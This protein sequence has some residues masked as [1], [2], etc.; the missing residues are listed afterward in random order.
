MHIFDASY[1]S[2]PNASLRPSDA[3]L[4]D[5]ALIQRQL[6]STRF[7]A[8]QPSIYGLDNSLLLAT[9]RHSGLERARG[10]AVVDETVTD[11][12]LTELRANGVRGVRFN[13]VQNG[14]TT[15]EMLESLDP[16]LNERNLHVQVHARPDQL[17]DALPLL[18][19]LRSELV[20]DHI[21][22]LA[23]MTDLQSKVEDALY[24][25][26]DTGRA[27]L[28]LS[29]PYLASGADDPYDDI[30]EC[31]GTI[32]RR[33]P[34]RIVWGTDWPHATERGPQNEQRMLA[35][36]RSLMPSA[37]VDRAVFVD[38]PAALYGFRTPTSAGSSS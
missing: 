24:R 14:V 8:V 6:G 5:Y 28:K 12:A 29:A 15:L 38:N 19:S 1:P 10:V 33:Y 16:R 37:A 20:I 32:A 27:W 3:S 30:A 17:I 18:Q 35:F 25:L 13:Q 22:R 2:I 36:F 26:L 31:I 21:G 9:L 4:D 11:A 23:S 34:Q 7:V